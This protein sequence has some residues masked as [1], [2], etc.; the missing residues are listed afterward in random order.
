MNAMKLL[1]VGVA[2]S[3]LGS[4]AVADAKKADN[5]KLIVGKWEVAKSHAGGP[6]EG[7]TVEFTKDGK[8]KVEGESGGMKMAFDGTYKVDGNKMVLKFKIGDQEE[9]VELTIDKLD[10][11]TCVT[12]SKEGK[13]ELK[14][15]K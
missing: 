12:T 7:G 10:E 8:I 9:P 4:V 1:A 13:V 15:K 2:V 3:L 5:A 11:T 6:P 14:R